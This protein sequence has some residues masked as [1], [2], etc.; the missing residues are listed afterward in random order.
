M[1]ANAYGGQSREQSCYYANSYASASLSMQ[2]NRPVHRTLPDTVTMTSN[3][4]TNTVDA[5][6]FLHMGDCGG[7]LNLCDDPTKLPV[8]PLNGGILTQMLLEKQKEKQKQS[9]SP[10]S[11]ISLALAADHALAICAMKLGAP[12]SR[13]HLFG[14]T[15]RAKILAAVVGMKRKTMQRFI[16]T[17]VLVYYDTTMDWEEKKVRFAL[18]T[19]PG[20]PFSKVSVKA[21]LDALVLLMS[22]EA[23]FEKWLALN[24]PSPVTVAHHPLLAGGTHLLLVHMKRDPVLE[25]GRFSDFLTTH[26][27]MQLRLTWDVG[28]G[29]IRLSDA[30]ANAFLTRTSSGDAKGPWE[31]SADEAL[32]SFCTRCPNIAR[33]RKSSH[34]ALY[35]LKKVR[36][37][38]RSLVQV[39]W[40]I[41]N[42]L[43]ATA[44]SKMRE[45][46]VPVIT[47]PVA[48]VP[49]TSQQLRASR[50]SSGGGFLLIGD[51]AAHVSPDVAHPSPGA[52]SPSEFEAA[53]IELYTKHDESKLRFVGK[54]VRKYAGGEAAALAC[55]KLKY[56]TTELPSTD[57]EDE[58]LK[59]KSKKRRR[60][61]ILLGLGL[62]PVSTH[63]E[64]RAL[65]KIEN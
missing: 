3:P 14:S 42:L 40:K 21:S 47:V 24:V 1:A 55:A 48:G 11:K 45:V 13:L 36:E 15:A 35:Y 33:L 19:T 58:Q 43:D 6:V 27:E 37:S 52:I 26:R 34:L 8:D 57:G 39:A 22:Q 10:G 28:S 9:V 25:Y 44:R 12:M 54:L 23:A 61:G 16:Q 51:D 31:T 50:L 46:P 65:K 56:Q 53:L 7:K 41:T 20:L 60:G 29:N 63:Q 38:G 2:P 4:H 59:K 30:E 17:N 62:I 5:C 49:L 32:A 64:L 18:T